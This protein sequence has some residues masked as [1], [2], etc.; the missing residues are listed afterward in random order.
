MDS[1]TLGLSA[2]PD[3][4]INFHIPKTGGTTLNI[5]LRANFPGGAYFDAKTGETAS[6]LWTHSAD[7]IEAAY[8]ALSPEAQRK[9]R[10]VSGAHLPMGVHTRFGRPAK[11]I[12]ILRDPIDRVVSTYYYI[13][14]GN[15]V[16]ELKRHLG[17]IE[18]YLES[19][20]DPGAENSQVRILCGA[21]ELDTGYGSDGLPAPFAAVEQRHLDM[22]K[23]N[24]EDLFLTAAP[25]AQF[26]L[27]VLMLRRIYGWEWRRTVFERIN[28]TKGRAKLDQIAPA[29]LR[30]IEELNRFDIELYR[31]VEARFRAQIEALGPSFAREQQLFDFVNGGIQAVGQ[32][33]PF[34]VRKRLAKWLIYRGGG[35]AKAA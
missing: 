24:I 35:R 26:S 32:V 1:S 6:A 5:L 2:A 3:L 8:R 21:P 20:I 33:I 25:L 16:P 18:D 13:Q 27:L 22:A 29:T 23:R 31:W 28:V 34:G 12:T 11:Y 9:V 4:L 19:H 17:T 30:R 7:A 14:T 15:P 10:C